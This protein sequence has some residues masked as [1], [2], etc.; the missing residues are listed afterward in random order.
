MLI[1][2]VINEVANV[3]GIGSVGWYIAEDGK[4][5]VCIIASEV[6]PPRV[7]QIDLDPQQALM[8]HQSLHTATIMLAMAAARN[9]KT[10]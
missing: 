5:H 1:N 7:L 2:Q 8:L 10:A 9:R 3:R 6:D 4:P